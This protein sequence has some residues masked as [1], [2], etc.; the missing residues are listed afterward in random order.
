MYIT[1]IHFKNFRCLAPYQI[2][3]EAPIVLITGSNGTGKTAILEALYYACYL[4]SFRTHILRDLITFEKT[5]F[6]INIS[7]EAYVDEQ[8]MYHDL[9][10]GF[11]Q[12]K[13]LVK[14]DGKTI[15]TYKDL[16]D[17]YRIISITT[18]DMQ[19]I[20]GYPQKRRTFIDQALSLFDP[21][22][23]SE[24]RTYRTIL[25]NQNALLHRQN[26]DD[27][28]YHLWSKQLWQKTRYLQERRIQMLGNLQ[29]K[30]TDLLSSF[31]GQAIKI[32]MRYKSRMLK[33]ETLYEEFSAAHPDLP[34]KE[35]TMQR[36]LFGIHL[37]DISV[38]FDTK[39]SKFYASRGQQKLTVFLIKAA[40]AQYITQH[41]GKVTLL[42]DDFMGDFD[43]NI[44]ARLY[45][46]LRYMDCQLIFTSPT[47]QGYLEQKL[48]EG[49]A[50][51]VKLTHSKL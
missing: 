31:F 2:A 24:L 51:E 21:S 22:Y 8:C 12:Q 44:L 49:G 35:K 5:A 28:L 45:D 4:R 25:Y 14:V 30:T 47:S 34:L 37:D 7:F 36:S 16:L 43:Q 40:L 39:Q 10:V 29:H 11:D 13:K 6:V 15:Q 19:L 46:L 18:D 42:L 9:Q 33:N 26:I 32:E 38:C 1:Q 23:V 17:Y 50:Q 3:I 41:K 48:L 27:S 20:A